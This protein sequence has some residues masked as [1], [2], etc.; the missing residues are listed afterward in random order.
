[1]STW[2]SGGVIDN[3]PANDASTELRQ[4]VD[5]IGRRSFDARVGQR[6]RPEKFDGALWRALEETGLDR[7]TSTPDLGATPADA[8]V[9]LRGLAR[10]GAA[11]PIAET[12]LLACWLLR[13]AGLEAPPG[14]LTVAITQGVISNGAITGTA[15]EVPWAQQSAAVVLA[16]R[17][18]DALHVGNLHEPAIEAGQNLAGEPCGTIEF[19]ISVDQL[20]ALPASV[21]DELSCRGAW[22][23]CCQTIG[24]LDAAAELTVA[25]TRERSQF[26]RPLSAFQAVQ[27]ALATMA[28]DIERARAATTVAVAAADEYGFAAAQTG[29][30][31]TV[32][33]VVLGQVVDPV[34]TI[35][36]QLHGAIGVTAE[37]PLWLA[38]LRAQAWICEFGSTTEHAR[39]LGAAGIAAQAL[40]DITL[41]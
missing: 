19:A 7:L 5:E 36:H 6:G 8:A 14:P 4:L 37:H 41:L 33:K 9:V 3:A 24:A 13:E 10:H 17:T 18:P 32:A 29:Q 21:A 34:T 28:G 30:A 23:R 27:H 31:V 20:T 11:V 12:D 38:T 2:L 26:G 25:H 22:A 39:R 15:R 40:W 1:L 16:L 35:A